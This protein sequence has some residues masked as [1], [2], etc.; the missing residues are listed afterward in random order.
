M[1]KEK[2][3]EKT[4]VV[5]ALKIACF[6]D[7]AFFKCTFDNDNDLGKSTHISAKMYAQNFEI[8][9][10]KGLG[11]VFLGNSGIGKTFL[12][13]CVAN[14]ICEQGKTCYFTNL[15]TEIQKMTDFSRA[16]EVLAHLKKVDCLILDDFGSEYWTDFFISRVFEI[17]NLRYVAYKPLILTT[18]L[19]SADFHNPKKNN[20]IFSRLLERNMFIELKGGDKRKQ[21]SMSN[22]KTFSEFFNYQDTHI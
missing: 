2:F 19:T 12:A 20:R 9:L 22:L 17:V 5:E 10:E 6:P 13:A 16:P 4:N 1:E 8:A 7:K 18:N 11:I 15:Q 14:A 3:F 21:I